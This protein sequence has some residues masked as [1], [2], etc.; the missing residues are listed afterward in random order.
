VTT[1]NVKIDVPD[2]LRRFLEN[3]T[4]LVKETIKEADED[5]LNLLKKDISKAAPQKTGKLA[6][7]IDVDF[8]DKR[9]F[10]DLVYARAVE[11]GH[12]AKAKHTPARMFLKFTDMGR[13][14][15]MRGIRTKKQPYFFKTLKTDRKKIIEIYDKAF[16]KLA[17]KV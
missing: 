9:V 15:F 4:P 11:L 10:S 1:V 8:Q 12:Y 13:D 2:R 7:S 14:I 5:V 17:S 6:H 16:D 3:P